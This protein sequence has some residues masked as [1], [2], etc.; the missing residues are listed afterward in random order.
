[1]T[2]GAKRRR[3]AALLATVIGVSCARPEQSLLERFF[4]ASRLRDTT[5][6]QGVATVVFEPRQDGIV[7]TF[8]ISGVSA[9]RME[10]S[11]PTRDI[12]VDAPVFL[13]D[14]NSVDKTLIVTIQRASADPASEWRIVGFKDAGA[15]PPTPRQ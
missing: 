11:K 7:R 3:V 10:E 2:S 12:T 1:V 6:L 5:A 13:M 9:E 8:A 14:G 15:S 4:A